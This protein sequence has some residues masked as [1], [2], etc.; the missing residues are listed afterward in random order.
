NSI[1][2]FPTEIESPV[3]QELDWNE[4]VVDIAITAETS[5]PE[6]KAYAEDLKR[7][8]KLDYDVSLVDVSGFS[9]HQYRVELDTQA[10]RQLGLSVGD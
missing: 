6:L 5:W 10:I 1:N 9:D 7:I 8:M 4:P 2:D 3:V